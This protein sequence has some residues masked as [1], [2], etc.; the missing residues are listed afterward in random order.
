M[1]P[2]GTSTSRRRTFRFKQTALSPPT[3][4]TDRE[5]SGGPAR[6]AALVEARAVARRATQAT[7]RAL[8][9]GQP[10]LPAAPARRRPPC[11][12]SVGR[13]KACCLAARR[14]G[15]VIEHR[16]HVLGLFREVGG[17]RL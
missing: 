15:V 11:R 9:L 10:A 5:A 1:S 12:L 7:R 17:Q 8:R 13:L 4:E 16:R 6:P 2:T 14:F 3:K